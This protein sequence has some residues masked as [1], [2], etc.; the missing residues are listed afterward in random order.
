MFQIVSIKEME[1]GTEKDKSSRDSKPSKPSDDVD[2]GDSGQESRS[3]NASSVTGSLEENRPFGY[4][5]MLKFAKAIEIRTSDDGFNSGRSFYVKA[6]APRGPRGGARRPAAGWRDSTRAHTQGGS[7]CR[8]WP[9][10]PGG[11]REAAWLIPRTATGSV[12]IL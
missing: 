1:T 3:R 4:S 2:A 5:V 10:A 9:A 11:E 12:R 6:S 8:S 7:A